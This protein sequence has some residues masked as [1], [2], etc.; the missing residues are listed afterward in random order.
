M[1]LKKL[2]ATTAACAVLAGVLAVP[3][4]AHG[5]G[6]HGRRAASTTYTTCAVENCTLNYRHDHNG[7]TYYGH[8]ASDGH[9]W[10]ANAEG[11]GYCH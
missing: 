1:K 8:S 9:S 6:H 2:L 4:M 5:G 3:A 10:C 11:Y 7:V